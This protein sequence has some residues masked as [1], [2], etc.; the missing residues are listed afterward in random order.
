MIAL[1]EHVQARKATQARAAKR[2][3]VTQPRL[4][5]L[6][7]GRIDKFSIDALVALAEHAGLEVRLKIKS[8]A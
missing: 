7:R 1:R 8:A 6:Q 2:L 5:D 4:N 3:G